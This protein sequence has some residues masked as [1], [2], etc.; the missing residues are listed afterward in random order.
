MKQAL[1]KTREW[2]FETG[3]RTLAVINVLMLSGWLVALVI[4]PD[5]YILPQAR[6]DLRISS[7]VLSM[8]LVFLVL[9]TTLNL[10]HTTTKQQKALG[11]WTLCTA[12]LWTLVSTHYWAGYPPI[13]PQMVIYPLITLLSWAG[14]EM[15]LAKSKMTK[16]QER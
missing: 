14:G 13:N 4:D 2:V 7:W 3:I 10:G 12:L 8:V 9:A 11:T 16:R 15:L 5:L 1:N 6:P